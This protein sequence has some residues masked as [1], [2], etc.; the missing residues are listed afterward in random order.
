M[1]GTTSNPQKG[2]INIELPNSQM[3]R[4]MT[5]KNL[6]KQI[7]FFEYLLEN[8]I[9]AD[10]EMSLQGARPH[11]NQQM[12]QF[13]AIHMTMAITEIHPEAEARYTQI[14]EEAKK[15]LKQYEQ[16]SPK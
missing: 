12:I 1:S 10:P 16:S 3:E 7:A 5:I 2:G 14:V 9:A 8:K 6:K 13:Q 15:A 11:P 4:Y